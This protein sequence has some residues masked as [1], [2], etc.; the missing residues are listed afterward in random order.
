MLQAKLVL[1]QKHMN[2]LVDI[3][4]SRLKWAIANGL[5]LIL[6]TNAL[7][8]KEEG[9]QKCLQARWENL[10]PP[11][12]IAIANVANNNVLKDILTI[13]Q[14]TWPTA[15]I[16]Q[17]QAKSEGWGVINSYLQP[18][19]LGVDRWLA[20]LAV[21]QSICG[22]ACI[23][24]CGTAITV[25]LL[26]QNGQHLGG[27]IAPGLVLMRQALAQGTAKLEY[28]P[29][30]YAIGLAKFTEA[31]LYNGTIMAAIGLIKQ[32]MQQYADH[33]MTLILTG[34]DALLIAQYLDLDAKIDND[35]VLQGLAITMEI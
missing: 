8:H 18:E 28:T 16:T 19:K 31:A 12:K 25:D 27:V 14:T 15:E 3:G 32:V 21:R 13:T 34:G 33:H 11:K 22:A 10:V 29:A 7:L 9:W 5:S 2:L 17:V 1:I 35:L 6:E 4:N 20:M 30:E 24:D 26:D 23:V